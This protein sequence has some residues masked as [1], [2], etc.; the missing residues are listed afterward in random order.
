MKRFVVNSTIPPERMDPV[1]WIMG[2]SKMLKATGAKDI[3][4]RTCYCC[5]EEGRVVCEFEADSKKSLSEGLKKIDF[6]VESVMETVKLTP[7]EAMPSF[8]C[9]DIG[10]ACNFEA[11]AK[12][13][14]ELM[15]KIAEHAS[16]A[17]NIK[18]MS[19]DMMK[20]VKKAIK[21]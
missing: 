12:T 7:E 10:M 5:S 18:T 16:K 2:T 9:R 20:K 14:D 19:P 15:K 21:M 8:K 6:P 17:H 13:E 3:K 4:F 1:A 11:T